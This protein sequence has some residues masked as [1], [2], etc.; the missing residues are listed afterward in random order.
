MIID[1]MPNLNIE[2][3]LPILSEMEVERRSKVKLFCILLSLG[4]F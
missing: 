1:D 4:I 2:K 3:V